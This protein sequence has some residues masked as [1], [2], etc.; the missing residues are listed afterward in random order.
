MFDPYAYLFSLSAMLA[1]AAITW[2][3]SILR[4]D[5]SIVDSLWGLLFLIGTVAYLLNASS[6]GQRSGIVLLLV[7]IWSLRLSIYITWRNW[8]EGE[9]HRYQKIRSNNSP[10]FTFKS[11]YIIFGFQGVLAWVIS[12]PLVVAISSANQIGALDVLGVALWVLGF[13]FEAVGDSQLAHF[14]AQPENAGKVMDTG[15]WRYTRHPNY[16]GEFCIWWGFY[17][18]ALS[19]GGW[20]SIVSPLLMTFLLLKFSGV[21][22]LEADISE[23]RPQYREYI[24]RTNTFFPGPSRLTTE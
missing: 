4:R 24:R 7:A 18:I 15:L 8:G 12:L 9:D 6:I 3:F 17:L 19:A 2:L 16:F 1:A 20:W 5:V 10:N 21:S 11:L 14:K 23:R 22:M 13:F